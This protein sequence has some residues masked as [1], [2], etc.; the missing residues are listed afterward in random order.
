MAEIFKKL[1]EETRFLSKIVPFVNGLNL[2]KKVHL[3]KT[4]RHVSL[5]VKTPTVIAKSGTRTPDYL[6]VS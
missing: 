3:Q 4:P 6:L 2:G 1:T 5:F